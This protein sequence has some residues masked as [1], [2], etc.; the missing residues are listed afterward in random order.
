MMD[1]DSGKFCE[2][3]VLNCFKI[4]PVISWGEKKYIVG[5]TQGTTYTKLD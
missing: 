1:I 2:E 3:Q 5:K 4:H